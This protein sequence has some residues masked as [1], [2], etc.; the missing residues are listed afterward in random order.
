M[1]PEDWDGWPQTVAQRLLTNSVLH[2]R[3]RYATERGIAFCAQE[4]SDGTWHGYPV[5]WKQV[6]AKIRHQL[7]ERKQVSQREIGRNLRHQQSIYPDRD[8]RLTLRFDDQ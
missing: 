8:R 2:E 3:K 5:P 1:A 6:P 4:T 7:I